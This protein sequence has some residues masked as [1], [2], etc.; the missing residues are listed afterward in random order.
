[1]KIRL[2][3]LLIIYSI[4][5]F[6]DTHSQSPNPNI[7]VYGY[8]TTWALQMGANVWGSSNYENMLY[9][10]LDRNACTD[11]I[12]FNANFNSDGTMAMAS[13]WYPTT[14]NTAWG[15]P[16]FQVPKRR[17]LNDYIHAAD[18]KVHLCFFVSGGGGEWTTQLNS[19]TYR[20]NMIKTIVDS[21]IGSTNRYDGVNFDVEPLGTGDTENVRLFFTQLRDT[22]DKYHQWVDT[23]QKPEI[24]VCFF[25]QWG[26]SSFWG[27]MAYLLSSIQHMSY[28][29]MGNWESISWYNAPLYKGTYSGL[30]YN[31]ASI[32]AYTN[33][34]IINGIPRSKLVM[35]CPFNYNIWEGGHQTADTS[36]GCYAPCLSFAS[37][38]TYPTWMLYNAAGLL[39]SGWN[40]SEMYYYLWNAF[41]DTA[42]TT[43]HYDSIYVAAWAGMNATGSANDF[44]IGFQDT[45][46][47][48]EILQYISSQGLQGAMIWE[49]PGAYVNVLPDARH[50][51][52]A[53]DHLLQA[54][55]K[56][57]LSLLETN[58]S[59][60]EY[61]SPPK[62]FI[63]KQNY[64]N[65]FN[66]TTIISFSIPSN[67]FV[68]LNI[69][70]LLGREV[71]VIISE[72]MPAGNY[73][74]QWNATN[75]S[76]GIYF[77]RIQAGNFIETKKLV[78]LK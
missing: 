27:T 15:Q 51:G 21:V 78:L 37:T 56:T 43:V 24:S 20:T 23:T 10:N 42:T 74:R 29:M 55:K 16:Y 50:L 7:R 13:D 62:K 14:G 45:T 77:Y 19:S 54:V 70:D 5:I 39:V 47:V 1:M 30:T 22:L 2:A 48:R 33:E 65:P 34:F 44:F 58:T 3:V 61:N 60:R 72:E 71:A 38:S 35:A 53:P 64:P 18:K 36:E 9:T 59:V 6:N 66:P 32:D 69:Y 57:R 11:Y 46:C 40:G 12:V 8:L 4:V 26:Q 41:L 68:S 52:L 75:I 76:S 67:S 63:L 28:N 17:F 31:V 25:D 73:T 49:L